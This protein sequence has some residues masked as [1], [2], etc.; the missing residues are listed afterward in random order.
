MV[1]AVQQLASSLRAAGQHLNL[2][3]GLRSRGV[4]RRVGDGVAFIVGLEDI[5][6]EELLALDSGA[7]GMAYDLGPDGL[8]SRRGG[9]GEHQLSATCTGRHT[10]GCDA[11]TYSLGRDVHKT[12]GQ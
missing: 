1:D 11:A 7:S 2:S 9:D 10:R 6:Y 12:T 4:I 5:G 3:A 8:C